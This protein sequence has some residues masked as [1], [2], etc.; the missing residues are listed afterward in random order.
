MCRLRSGWAEGQC[1]P[2]DAM[3]LAGRLGTVVEHMAEMPATTTAMFLGT[4][5]QQAGVMLGDDRVGERCIETRPA[6][7]A[8]EL[9]R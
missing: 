1:E 3:A 7:A 4:I 9:G 2:V 5:H 6:G 8:F